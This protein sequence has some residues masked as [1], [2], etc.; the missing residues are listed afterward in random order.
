[1]DFID[2]FHAPQS[3]REGGSSSSSIE[4]RGADEE[5]GPE[6][7]APARGGQRRRTCSG[8]QP[9]VKRIKCVRGFALAINGG[10]DRAGGD[11]TL[12]ASPSPVRATHPRRKKR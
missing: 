4:W 2:H 10:G 11:V 3:G 6:A 9:D 7:R 12:S 8:P 5:A 1:M